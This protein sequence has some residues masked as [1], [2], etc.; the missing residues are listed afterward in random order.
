MSILETLGLLVGS[1]VDLL[2]TCCCTAGGFGARQ[3]CSWSVDSW[4]GLFL[5]PFQFAGGLSLQSKSEGAGQSV[6]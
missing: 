6:A 4:S 2:V 3:I 1:E 5:I